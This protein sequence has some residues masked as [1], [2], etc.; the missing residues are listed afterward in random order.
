MLGSCF[1]SASNIAGIPGDKQEGDYEEQLQYS[2]FL[3]VP[4]EW[5]TR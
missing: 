3:K 5:Q 2:S 1:S 4:G